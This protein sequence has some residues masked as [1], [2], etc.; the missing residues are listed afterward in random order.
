[1]TKSRE[2][3]GSFLL[4]RYKTFD[5]IE[6]MKSSNDYGLLGFI[7]DQSPRKESKSYVRSFMEQ[8]SLFLQVLKELRKK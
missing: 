7:G 5:F 4:S 2:K 6:S 1:M 3:Y 8:T